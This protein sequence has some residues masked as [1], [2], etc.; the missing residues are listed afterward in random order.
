MNGCLIEMTNMAS[1]TVVFHV[2]SGAPIAST[3]P[4]RL[5]IRMDSNISLQ[6]AHG[7]QE[8]PQ[9]EQLAQSRCQGLGK[10]HGLCRRPNLEYGDDFQRQQALIIAK[11][12]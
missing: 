3:P 5:K 2:S 4:I 9:Y 1:S 12:M 6:K 11:E 10:Y 7:D 8:V